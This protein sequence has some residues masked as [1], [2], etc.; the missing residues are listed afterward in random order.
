MRLVPLLALSKLN[1][2][3][4]LLS[5]HRPH[6]LVGSML[7]SVPNN[8]NRITLPLTPCHLRPQ[9]MHQGGFCL[10]ALQLA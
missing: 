3:K 7:V 8:L 2:R 5:I 4:H 9:L 10:I 1:A 6:Q